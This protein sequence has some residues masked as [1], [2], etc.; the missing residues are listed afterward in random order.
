MR[1]LSL[2][3]GAGGGDLAA[4][5]LLGWETIGYVEKDEYCQRII[6][7]RQEDGTFHVAPIFGD[8]RAFI[9]GGYARRY[10]GM[11]DVITAGFPCQPFSV[12]GR[13]MGDADGRDMWPA[14]RR[15][16]GVI[17]PRYALLE[18][19]PGL[20]T[21]NGGRY[22][23]RILRELATMGYDARW[24]VLGAADC[25]APHVRKRVWILANTYVDTNTKSERVGQ[26]SIQS[27]RPRQASTDIDRLGEDVANTEGE[28]SRSGQL[29]IR[30]KEKK[31]TTSECSDDAYSA[32]DRLKGCTGPEQQFQSTFS[33]PGWWEAEPEVG[34][35]VDGLADWSHQLRACGNGQV[36]IVAA[37]AWRI[38]SERIMK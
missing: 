6:K 30:T 16:I 31:P 1:H 17:R 13:R 29:P 37:T 4:Q 18:N 3:C 32:S 25:G 27:R 20:L 21:W 15:T 14:T 10:R 22:F 23:G 24:C 5:H 8:I 11:V 7:A 38:L 35:V 9:A 12:A 26:L 28:R 36:P 19:V 2:F 34:R 33:N